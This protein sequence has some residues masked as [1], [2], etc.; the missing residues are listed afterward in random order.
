LG[1]SNIFTE[2]GDLWGDLSI[3]SAETLTKE[4]GIELISI[5]KEAD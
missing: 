4:F 2:Y 3:F 1:Y 5:A